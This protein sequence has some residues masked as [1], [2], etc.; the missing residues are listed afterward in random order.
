M[1]IKYDADNLYQLISDFYKISG[2]SIAILSKDRKRVT[3]HVVKRQEFCCALQ[4]EHSHLCRECDTK[5]I[6]QCKNTRKPAMHMCHAGLLDAALPIIV[7]DEIV[8]FITM[9]QVRKSA[10]FDS[11]KKKVPISLIPELEKY[12]NNLALLSE[13]QMES[14]I[15][16]VNAVITQI[17]KENMIEITTEE[18]SILA[19][20]YIDENL[21]EDLSV[22]KLCRKLNV[23]KNRL[24]ECFH[25][26]FNSTINE[27]IVKKR[28]RKAIELL[29]N[30]NI[31]IDDVAKEAGFSESSY[32]YKV[33]RKETG[34]TPGFF[35]KNQ[36]K[37]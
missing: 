15:R 27:Y 25:L 9:G 37:I 16:I 4:K 30:D 34:Y 23:S 8:G 13:E 6:T 32:F 17:V 10:D 12:Y 28:I 1:K 21:S 24:Y 22:E 18:L 14:A 36:N 19:D 3:N 5:I 26:C 33:F 31:S 35:K 2:I 11:V 29:A 20:K 7:E